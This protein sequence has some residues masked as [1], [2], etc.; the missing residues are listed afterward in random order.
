[1]VKKARFCPFFPKKWK[2]QPWPEFLLQK[3]GKNSFLPCKNPCPVEFPRCFLGLR[4]THKII[5]GVYPR[6][7]W[8]KAFFQPQTK[9]LRLK[10]CHFF[11][12]LPQK[13]KNQLNHGSHDSI[14]PSRWPFGVSLI[15]QR[16]TQRGT[17]WVF[18]GFA[19]WRSQWLR[20]FMAKP[21]ARAQPEAS[22]TKAK[23]QSEG[24]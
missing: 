10:K 22:R 17:L 14:R 15:P 16:K 4:G 20:H 6:K 5:S 13:T 19:K 7:W 9:P 1:M 12:F 2:K 18:I 11:D 24:V 3:M 23:L 8:K 21:V